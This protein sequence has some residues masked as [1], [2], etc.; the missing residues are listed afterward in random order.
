MKKYST[1]R[2]D[3][4]S[5]KRVIV[6]KDR[7]IVPSKLETN[8]SDLGCRLIDNIAADFKRLRN[9]VEIN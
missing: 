7:N 9:D 4:A 5:Y 2:H 3:I 6:D 8:G 1:H